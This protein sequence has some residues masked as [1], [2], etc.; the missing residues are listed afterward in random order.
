MRR[1][2][3]QFR[4]SWSASDS[5]PSFWARVHTQM[6]KQISPHAKCFPFFFHKNSIQFSKNL[7]WNLTTLHTHTVT[8]CL[9]YLPCQREETVLLSVLLSIFFF[10]LRVALCNVSSSD[11]LTKFNMLL[12]FLF[13]HFGWKISCC[14]AAHY[15]MSIIFSLED[16]GQGREDTFQT[17][18][19]GLISPSV[20]VCSLHFFH[21]E[22]TLQLLLACQRT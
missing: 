12:Q 21:Q 5:E 7:K 9:Q 2:F 4:M 15:I 20:S 8:F 14:C 16:K 17:L 1:R 13:S 6:L 11:L 19:Q 18:H 22:P 10:N 3:I